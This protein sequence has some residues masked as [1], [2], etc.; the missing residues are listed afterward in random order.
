[1]I[2]I[3]LV[4]VGVSMSFTPVSAK[5]FVSSCRFAKKNILKLGLTFLTL[6]GA[7]FTSQAH[8]AWTPV[9]GMTG[10]VVAVA[11]DASDTTGTAYAATNNGTTPIIYRI[12][13]G[14]ATQMNISG[15]TMAI[16]LLQFRTS[17]ILMIYIFI[18][19]LMTPIE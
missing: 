19:L 15:M 11:A 18:L 7:I 17:L 14:I 16:Q 3:A 12:A 2:K 6:I 1:M 13:N 5:R 4:N 10:T 9:S 8:A